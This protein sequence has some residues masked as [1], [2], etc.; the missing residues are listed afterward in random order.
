MMNNNYNK[1]ISKMFSQHAC[2]QNQHELITPKIFMMKLK[3]A[4][5]MIAN[6]IITTEMEKGFSNWPHVSYRQTEI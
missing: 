2:C 4:L 6:H 1:S 5:V 3:Q